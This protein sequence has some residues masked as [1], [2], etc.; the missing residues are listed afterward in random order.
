MNPYIF[1]FI[2]LICVFLVVSFFIAKKMYRH[3]QATNVVHAK[4]YSIL[5]YLLFVGI[6]TIITVYIIL[7]NISFER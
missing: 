7:M 4:L 1:L 6:L 2:V 3:F 5:L